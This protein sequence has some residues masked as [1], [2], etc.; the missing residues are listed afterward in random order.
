VDEATLLDRL[1]KI[2]ALH[3]G[4]T[5][6]GERAAAEKA[7]ARILALLGEM[8]AKAPAEEYTF[9]M[10]DA[11]S[12]RLFMA[13]LRRYDLKPYRYRGQRYTTVMV[14]VPKVFVEQTLWPEFQEFSKVLQEYLSEVTDKVIS[15]VLQQ[16]PDDE[17]DERNEPAQLDGGVA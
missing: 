5:F 4:T 3:A 7:R 17:I 13:L 14:R 16:K 12:R 15:D 8:Q 10:A 9:R 6:D 1:A 2:E 11:W